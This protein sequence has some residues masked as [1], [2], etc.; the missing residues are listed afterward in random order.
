[1]RWCGTVTV[2]VLPVP[3]SCPV[4]G[5]VVPPAAVMKGLSAGVST[6][7][8]V[9]PSSSLSSYAPASPAASKPD[10]PWMPGSRKASSNAAT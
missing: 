9:V 2:T 3:V 5:R 4:H 1:V 6:T 8:P 7:R 10:C